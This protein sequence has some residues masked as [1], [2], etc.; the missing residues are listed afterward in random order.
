VKENENGK[1][2]NLWIEI[3]WVA[4]QNGTLNNFGENHK[5]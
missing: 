4:R 3:Y 5:Y 2:I 1:E